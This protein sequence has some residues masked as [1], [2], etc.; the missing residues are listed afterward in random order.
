MTVNTKTFVSNSQT[1][2]GCTPNYIL[3]R[4]E[5]CAS[6]TVLICASVVLHTRLQQVSQAATRAARG[7]CTIVHP[8]KD[9]ALI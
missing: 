1:T 6:P 4:T 9:Q 5:V 3:R 7:G 8:D 2:T